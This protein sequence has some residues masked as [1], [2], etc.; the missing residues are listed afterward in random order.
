MLWVLDTRKEGAWDAYRDGSV[1]II[2]KRAGRRA[3]KG[4]KVHLDN[5]LCQFK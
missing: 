5:D 2:E 3:L 4:D 1:I